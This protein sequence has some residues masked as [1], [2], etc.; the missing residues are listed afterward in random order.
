M[1]VRDEKDVLAETIE[2]VRPIADEILVLDTG[3]TDQT[4][5][6][7]ERLGAT[8]S[9]APWG[10]DFSAARNRLL[11]MAAGQWV[12]WLDAGER[13]TPESASEIGS[14]VDGQADPRTVYFLM[15]EMPSGEAAVSNE[16]AAKPRLMPRRP[17][18]RFSGRV[19]ESLEPA[20]GAAGLT[21]ELAPGRIAGHL[22]QQDPDR[23]A[24]KARRDLELV[25][26]EKADGGASRPA[27]LLASGDA[28]SN[29]GDPVAA[30][31]AFLEA[32]RTAPHGSVE[33]LEAYYG[34]LA[35]F[36]GEPSAC[37]RQIAL[38]VSALEIY[39][40]DTQLLCAAGSYLQGQGQF[41]LAARAFQT[42]VKHG[43]VDPRT[44]HLCEIGEM[45]A[46]FLSLT[47]QV[48][49]RDDEARRAL[50]EALA[51]H[52]GSVRL[53]RHVL[54]LE[55]KHGRTDEALRL[56]EAIPIDCQ[57]REPLRNA[58]RGACRAAAQEWLAAL[59]L[60]QSAYVA[61]CRD[62]LCLR[63]LA[64]TLLSNGQVE[65]AK[66]V[67]NEWLQRE[68]NSAEARTYLEAIQQQGPERPVWLPRDPLGSDRSRRIRVDPGTSVI[69]A[70][71]TRMPIIH[72]ALS[73]DSISDAER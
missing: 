10:D 60:L 56:A 1:I 69:H 20:V 41:D 25:A 13:V 52:Q 68:P 28:Y 22:R 7:A 46:V 67:L 38:C 11:K 18:L 61:G 35:T 73:T 17:E 50:R 16:Q 58:I 57:R 15:V 23:K 53:R 39:P 24:R 19:R 27:L 40:L 48:Q 65:A 49:G 30:R 63:W 26:L 43:R 47:L 12:L 2:S 8:V 62:P 3:S 59:G 45:A 37:D 5:A 31:R 4:P 44:W 33:M 42:A 21:M 51:R 71:P 66:P 55:I 32:V 72:Q 29:L 64:V 36:E 54:D 9:R 70:T 34:L 6:I 14:F